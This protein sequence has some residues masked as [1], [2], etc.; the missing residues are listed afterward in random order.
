MNFNKKILYC[1]QIL[2][3]IFSF[4]LI[5]AFYTGCAKVNVVDKNSEKVKIEKVINTSIGWA[6][7][8]DTSLLYSIMAKDTNFFIYH[9]DS[10]ST[11][12]GIENFK[13]LSD[14]WMDTK[15]VATDF[16]VKNLRLNLSAS[17][18]VAWFSCLLDD[19]ALWDGKFSGWDNARWTG[20]L[21]KRNNNW[22]IVQMHFSFPK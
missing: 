16:K 10:L 8:K 21:E 14:F 1:P 13:K 7:T 18:D 4:F 15:F 20:V 6:M 17:G 11:I 22:E 12:I 19:H 5:F 2:L 9:P 3:L